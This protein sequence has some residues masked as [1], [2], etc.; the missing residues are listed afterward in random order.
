[1]WNRGSGGE[2]RE[3]NG[4]EAPVKGGTGVMRVTDR[5]NW[6]DGMLYGYY[7]ALFGGKRV[8]GEDKTL[9]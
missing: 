7:S 9:D 3:A 2:M 5:G 1:M 6:K 4:L 8:S